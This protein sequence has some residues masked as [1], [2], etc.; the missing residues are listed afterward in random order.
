MTT[1]SQWTCSRG[2]LLG[3]ASKYRTHMHKYPSMYYIHSGRLCLVVVRGLHVVPSYTEN[4]TGGVDAS[5]N[6]VLTI[7][8]PNRQQGVIR[9]TWA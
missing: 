4:A 3:S 2:F 8:L 6:C 1:D 7:P 5:D 9:N